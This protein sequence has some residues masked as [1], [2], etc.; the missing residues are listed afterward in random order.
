MEQLLNQAIH[1]LTVA[2]AVTAAVYIGGSA[3][4]GL[5]GQLTSRETSDLKAVVGHA[6]FGLMIIGLTGVLLIILRSHGIE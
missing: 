4:F 3:M 2:P 1:F 5:S 6:G